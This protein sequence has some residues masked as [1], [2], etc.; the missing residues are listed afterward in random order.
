VLSW[1]VAIGLGRLEEVV[2]KVRAGWFDGEVR[3][4]SRPL[5]VLVQEAFR[6]DVSV[7]EKTLTRHHGGKAPKR[8]RNDI[9]D[10]AQA[11]GFSLRYAPS[12]RNG[13]HRSDRGNA[14]L[15]NVAIAEARAFPLPHVRQRRIVLSA[16]LT[17][18]PWLSFVCAHL[19]TRRARIQRQSGR[20]HQAGTL[21]R[22]LVA[23][24]G[25]DQ[26]LLLGADFNSYRGEREPMF[27]ELGAAGFLRLAHS[28]A[29]R[30]TFHAR[31][32]RMQLDHFLIR[33]SPE[34][35]KSIQV[36]R[37]DETPDDRG[38]Y[39]FG[40]DHHPLLARIE[41]APRNRRIKRVGE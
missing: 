31:G 24:W 21:A 15:A 19:D 3:R 25:T 18:L 35:V 1:N 5:V 29:T 37:L 33:T 20:R 12:M 16:Q 14:I 41:L 2:E 13:A 40:S 11:L 8:A 30:H 6:S 34:S 9:V 27:R 26:S 28:G 10:A 39:V 7:P 4:V 23:D 36:M 22:Q 32:V 38:R 17:G